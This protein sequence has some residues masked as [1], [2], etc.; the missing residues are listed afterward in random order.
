MGLLPSWQ[1]W[2]FHGYVFRKKANIYSS[3]EIKYENIRT[4]ATGSR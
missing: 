4:E 2:L 3:E 1:E